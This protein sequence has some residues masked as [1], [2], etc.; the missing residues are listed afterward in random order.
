MK[1]EQLQP[2]PSAPVPVS[3]SGSD[4]ELQIR[5]AKQYRRDLP[6]VLNTVEFLAC[7]N[8][9]T[10]QECFFALKKGGSE[11]T[12]VS[13]RFAEIVATS[14]TNLR[15]VKTISD[16][17]KIDGTISA[18]CVVHDLESNMALSETI[19]K[20]IKGK[21]GLYSDDL[22]TLTG[23]A[24]QS[25]AMRNCLFG[26]IPKS[27]FSGVIEKVKKVATGQLTGET[28]QTRVQKA[29]KYFAAAGIDKE[30]VLF[31]LGREAIEQ[32]TEDD[33]VIL[34][35]I[36]SGVSQGEIT[37]DHALPPTN[38]ENAKEKGKNI[39]ASAKIKLDDKAKK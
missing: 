2:T 21:N 36:R 33:L 22:I 4:I 39:M 29:I 20:S 25:I 3:Q 28:L 1:T 7:G 6:T 24:A 38:K 30:R 34:T 13:I 27:F 5:T 37:L 15:V 31:N 19:V 9:E 18:T 16:I 8:Q 32:V 23:R 11:I 12:G 26:V 35:G 14:W 17:N 10:A